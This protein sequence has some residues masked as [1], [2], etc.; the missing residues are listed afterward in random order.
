MV[1]GGLPDALHGGQRQTGAGLA[2]GA[3]ALVGGGAAG[4]AEERLNL[5]H[6][7]A[8]GRARVE[9]LPQKSPEG[10]AQGIDPVAAV[11]ALLSLT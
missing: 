4:Q 7:L 1:G 2:V 3:G 6:D 11:E 9:H 10:A 8:T 5:A